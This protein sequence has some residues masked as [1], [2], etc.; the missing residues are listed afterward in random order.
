[1]TTWSPN[2]AS[3]TGPRYLAIADALADDIAAGRLKP[4]ERLPTHRDLAWS[5]RVTVGT[6]T[7]AYAEAERRGLIA[8]EVGRGTFIRDPGHDLPP[9]PVNPGANFLDLSRNYPPLE[10][11]NR[12]IADT[13]AD[14]S[15]G[16][17][18][19]LLTY[20]AIPGL[21]GHREAG[22]QWIGQR[23]IKFAPDEVVIANGTQHATMLAFSAV[24]RPGDTILTEQLTYYGMKA[25]G[26]MFAY[27]LQGVPLDEFGLIPEA[28][29]AACRAHAPK[30][31]YC[32]PTLQNPT[33]ATMPEERRIEIAA[34]CRRHDVVIIEDDC[35]GFLSDG[36]P[37][38][39]RHAPGHSVYITGL[40]KAVAPGL[41]IGYLGTKM[42]LA[43]R[44]ERVLRATTWTAT[45]LMA[46]IAARLIRGGAAKRMAAWQKGEAEAR[47]LLAARALAGLDY[48]TDKSSFH[49][50]LRLPEPWRREEFT[51]AARRR[52][53]GVAPAENFA[54]G[55][56]PVPHAVRVCLAAA[57][58]RERLE[59]GLNTLAQLAHDVPA[60]AHATV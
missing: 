39:S 24:A 53:L 47:Q 44:F 37:P 27:K 45:P 1:M 56:M 55:R 21:V 15:R 5:L 19:H 8:G 36:P 34:I 33:T 32:L 42:A 49:I 23:G 57:S 26:G 12:A 40:S 13:L 54:V 30:A 51:E 18:T 10:P 35:Y 58:T 46:E 50:W 14:I 6:I 43:D 17:I 60:M 7:R 11:G 4:G 22:A 28:L 3:R 59:H 9:A 52:G 41:R 16:D 38:L 31:L 20:G 29:D 2:I 25:L 48:A